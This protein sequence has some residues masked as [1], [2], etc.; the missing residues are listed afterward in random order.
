MNSLL[1]SHS[2]FK[3]QVW[4][5]LYLKAKD[6]EYSLDTANQGSNPSIPHLTFTVFP[7]S[8]SSNMFKLH[9][10]QGSHNSAVTIYIS[11]NQVQ[12]T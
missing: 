11:D 4:Q 3:S 10:S 8:P 5:P 2:M 6:P 12:Y 1:S 7:R 9:H